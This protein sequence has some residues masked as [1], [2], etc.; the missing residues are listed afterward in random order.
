ML[1]LAATVVVLLVAV[2]RVATADV[3]AELAVVVL[4]QLVAAKL[5]VVV[6]VLLCSTRLLHKQLRFT[7]LLLHLFKLPLSTKHQLTRLHCH[8]HPLLI[9]VPA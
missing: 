8:Q 1:Q 6:Q 9:Q 5:L 3:L 4:H 2:L 7:K